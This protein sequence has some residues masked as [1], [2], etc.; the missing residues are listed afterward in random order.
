MD[1]TVNAAM[2]KLHNRRPPP[3][4]L[5]TALD[6]SD[7]DSDLDLRPKGKGANR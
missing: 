2:R 1:H 5:A 7:S 6:D 4:L 3:D